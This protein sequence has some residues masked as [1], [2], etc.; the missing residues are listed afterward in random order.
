MIVTCVEILRTEREVIGEEEVPPPAAVVADVERHARQDLLLH[1]DAEL[2]VVVPDAPSVLHVGIDARRPEWDAE[3]RVAPGAATV[4]AGR[5][6][7]LRGRIHQIAVRNEIMVAIG[8]AA[9]RRLLERHR[10]VVLRV[11]SPVLRGLQ[12]LAEVH[13]QRRL[14]VAEDVEGH[15]HPRRDVVEA[16]DAV[17]PREDELA[18]ELVVGG[19]AVLALGEPAPRVFI[20]HR[21]LHREPAVRPLILRVEAVVARAVALDVRADAHRELNRVQQGRAGA[22]ERVGQLVI[23]VLDLPV[24]L[25]R[26]LLT[27]P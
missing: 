13:L 8:P 10:R 3:V 12:V 24:H 6:V 25:V 16:G 20:A 5:E 4:A 17:L 26:R 19:D 15:A 22:V 14:A 21:G 2:P 1:G 11:E 9:V 18:A 23:D 27:R 7:V